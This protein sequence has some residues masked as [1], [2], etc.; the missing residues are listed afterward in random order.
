MQYR[1]RAYGLGIRSGVRLPELIEDPHQ[2]VDVVIAVEQ[3]AR[4]STVPHLRVAVNHESVVIEHPVVGRCRID[5]GRTITIQPLQD[6]PA[7][8]VR[9][10]LLGPAFGALLRQRGFLT[11]HAS[12]V[13]I[14]GEA[15][16]FLGESGAGKSTLAAACASAG[17]RVIADDVVC[18]ETGGARPVVFP[19][20]PALKLDAPAAAACGMSEGDTGCDG[21]HSLPKRYL[22]ALPCPQLAVPIGRIFVLE[23]TER[24]IVENLEPRQAFVELLRHSY[25]SRTLQSFHRENH[26]QQ[27]A[28]LARAVPVARL[29][30]GGSLQSLPVLKR[31]A[32]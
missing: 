15:V 30:R 21:V 24:A 2:H 6:A 1:Y 4:V 28:A 26:M 22:Q 32:V 31:V 16:L 8:L 20:F 13:A 10:M 29:E 23:K 11:L 19:A 5:H 3:H 18:V 9:M 12:A 14:R 25:G 27:C 7:A 17:Q